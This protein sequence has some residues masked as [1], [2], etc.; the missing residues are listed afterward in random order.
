MRSRRGVAMLAALWLV[1]GITIVALEFALVGQERR[2]FGLAAADRARQTASALGGFHMMQARLEQ[3]LRTGPQSQAG[4]LG[5]L[6]SSDPWLDV[7]SLYSGIV[8]IDSQKVSVEVI[9]LGTKLNINNMTEL[10]FRNLITYTIG[11]AIEA[12]YLAQAIMDWRDVDD[13]SRLHGGEKDDYLKAGLLR[14]PTNTGFHDVE[15]LLDVKGMSRDVY[16]IISPYLTTLGQAQVNLNTAPVA[17][18]RTL[19]GM[20]DGIVANILNMRSRGQRIASVAE[21]I[22]QQNTGRQISVQVN[23]AIQV[24]NNAAQQQISARAGVL[25]QNLQMTILAQAS[26]ASKPTRLR[27]WIQRSQQGQ[28]AVAQVAGEEWR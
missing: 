11:D 27:V 21:V 13:L 19:P 4:N 8:M 9:D 3:A 20:N 17:V 26:P 23:G 7:D 2:E 25:T 6:R 12:E 18:L 24:L 10:D 28:Q 16:A 5:R 14:L 15:E 1:V 22:P